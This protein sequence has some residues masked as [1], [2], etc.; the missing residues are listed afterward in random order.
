MK[1]QVGFIQGP[2]GS[3]FKD[4]VTLAIIWDGK[5]LE[6]LSDRSSDLTFGR[7]IEE[8]ME[9]EGDKFDLANALSSGFSYYR[10]SV[11]EM[12]PKIEEELRMQYPVS[13]RGS[14]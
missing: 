1:K 6:F 4:R 10:T 13:S 3:D 9:R 11:E 7:T 8:R 12:T 5:S 14:K 2:F